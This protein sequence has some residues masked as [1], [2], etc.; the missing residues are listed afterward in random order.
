M[1]LK[2]KL[3][4]L[5]SGQGLTQ[6]ELTA[7][8][9]VSRQTVYKWERGIAVPSA[10]NFIAL[11]RLY[12]VPLEELVNGERQPEEGPPVAVAEEPGAPPPVEGEAPGKRG[13]SIAAAIGLGAC[14]LV[15]VIASVI[16][17]WSTVF[18]KPEKTII[19]TEDMEPDYIDPAELAPFNG[20]VNMID[21]GTIQFGG[22]VNGRASD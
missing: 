14:L 8:I 13:R 18:K 7:K 6:G 17:I 1:G 16:T 10:E 19:K 9:N 11:G 5:R 12:G 21:D 4:E 22:T 15:V 3:A 20:E 2:E